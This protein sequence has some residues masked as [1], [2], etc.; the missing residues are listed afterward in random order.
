MHIERAYCVELERVVD[1]YEARDFYF[2]QTPPRK[3]FRFLCSD[4]KCREAN[5]TKVTGVNYDKLVEESDQ[6]VKPHFRENTDHIDDC[7]W[8]ELEMALNE[9]RE[10]SRRSSKHKTDPRRPGKRKSLKSSNIV[11]IF[12]PNSVGG[13]RTVERL[14]RE[15]RAGIKR[16][17]NKRDRIDALKAHLRD[18]PNQTSF[19]ENVVHSYYMLEPDD[20][21][22]TRLK[23]G[24]GA[25]R[26][27]RESFRP[28]DQYKRDRSDNYI[29]SGGV[30]VKR[31]GPNFS[32]I[33]IS[34]VE[35]E[36]KERRVSLYIEKEKLERYKHRAYLTEMLEK[37]L[38]KSADYATCFF[39]GHIRPSTKND[40]WLDIDLD[41]FDNLVMILRWK[42]RK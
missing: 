5:A 35:L 25:W 19:L 7:E 16:I 22:L 34:K 15:K 3:R 40:A 20:R 4:E 37:L 42:Q 33:F 38:S 28:I 30:W 18:N 27:Y 2:R 39:Y 31:Y 36:G 21:R 23:I 29:Y 11:D 26:S 17:P 41:H 12:V 13:A 24:R 14:A 9:L 1:I 32:L 8:I 6:Y 10:E